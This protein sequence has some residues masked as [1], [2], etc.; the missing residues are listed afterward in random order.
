MRVHVVVVVRIVPPHVFPIERSKQSHQHFALQ[1]IALIKF[2][3]VF[4]KVKVNDRL[5]NW[6]HKDKYLAN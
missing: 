6:Q 3:C 2:N 4:Y 1:K 5:Q